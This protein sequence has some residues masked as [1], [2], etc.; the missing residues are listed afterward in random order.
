MGKRNL[1]IIFISR[2]VTTMDSSLFSIILVSGLFL[3][4]CCILSFC[5]HSKRGQ[6]LYR[7]WK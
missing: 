4:A 6:V 2:K 1:L 7:L 5:D 3:P